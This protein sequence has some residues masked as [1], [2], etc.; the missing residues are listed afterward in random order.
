MNFSK[1]T[2]KL[3]Y[4][5][6]PKKPSVPVNGTSKDY[7]AYTA[8]LQNYENSLI[9]YKEE[10]KK[11]NL[12]GM[13]LIKLFENDCMEEVGLSNHPKRE[14]VWEYAW[15]EGHSGGLNDVYCIIS[16]IAEILID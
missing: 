12:E 10:L 13:R 16:D 7:E 2:N 5:A 6:K 4:P 14:K 8:K 3:T 9:K 15:K 11:Y 1:Y